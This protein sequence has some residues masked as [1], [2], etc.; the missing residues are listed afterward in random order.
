MVKQMDMARGIG[1]TKADNLAGQRWLEVRAL[2]LGL[3]WQAKLEPQ[4]L[5][6]MRQAR[7]VQGN[8]HAYGSTWRWGD[9]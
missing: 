7:S 1:P 6:W 3:T 8:L 9:G 5:P 2:A 4:S